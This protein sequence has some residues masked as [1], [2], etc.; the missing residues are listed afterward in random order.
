MAALPLWP[1]CAQSLVAG[2]ATPLQAIAQID[3]W[4]KT[5]RTITAPAMSGLC[6]RRRLRDCLNLQQEQSSPTESAMPPRSE[7]LTARQA[8]I[9]DFIRQTVETEGRPPTRLEVCAA[10]GFRSPNA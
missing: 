3:R 2:R 8:E 5:Q 6:C 9:L 10:F 1:S 7:S 4:L